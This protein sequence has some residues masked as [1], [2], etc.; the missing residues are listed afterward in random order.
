MHGSARTHRRRSRVAAMLRGSS[1]LVTG[2]S[3]FIG[4]H[5]VDR[6]LAAGHRPRIFDV[7]P[8]AFHPDVDAVEAD[9][10][11]LD[12]VCA[13]LRGCDAVIHLAASADVNEVF[14]DPVDAETR[15][16]RG[17]L[18]VLEG[19]RRC[20]VGRVVYA[21][22]IWAYSDTAGDRLEESMPLSAPAH[23][24]TSTKL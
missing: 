4:S 18:H 6:L 12:Q 13:A 19:V 7:R 20:G 23:F 9:L 8:S 2:G 24:Y 22:T 17:T 21:S 11:D 15:N 16:V 5:V 14:A 10:N 1:L 3:G